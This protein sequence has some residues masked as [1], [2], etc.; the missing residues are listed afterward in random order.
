MG[1]RLWATVATRCIFAG[2][3]MMW[4][5]GLKKALEMLADF[6]HPYRLIEGR[7]IVLLILASL[8]F[9]MLLKYVLW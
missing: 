7:D 3:T 5:M 1:L 4:K 8:M 6:C 2:V 9:S